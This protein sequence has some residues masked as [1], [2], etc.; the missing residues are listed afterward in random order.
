MKESAG[1]IVLGLEGKIV[2]VE[3]HGN[4]WSFPKG[5]VESGETTLA[6]AKREIFEET[7]VSD[8]ELVCE[9]GSYERYSI[10]KDGT[11]E[12]VED[13]LR[14]RTLFL[15]ATNQSDFQAHDPGGEVTEVRWV[16]LD[17]AFTL[18]THH[19]DREFLESVR[20][21]IFAET[22]SSGVAYTI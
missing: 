22:K 5:R 2:L 17:E 12:K 14:R 13:G 4:S 10:G 11:S 19:K 20:D 9:L 21:V 16:T 1:G 18:L 15:F 8:L 6:A 7:G 3:Q